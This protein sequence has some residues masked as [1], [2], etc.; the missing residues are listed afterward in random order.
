MIKKI[1]SFRHAFHSKRLI[2][3]TIWYLIRNFYKDPNK[4]EKAKQR[5]VFNYRCTPSSPRSFNEYNLWIKYN[6]LNDFWKR[7]ADKIECKKALTELGFGNHCSKTLTVF[8]DSSEINL[9]SLPVKFVLKTNHDSGSVFVC[10]KN[11]TD[12]ASIFVKLDES[13]KHNYSSLNKEWFYEDIRP[14]I[15]AEEYLEPVGRELVDYKLFVFNGKYKCGYT[16]QNRS[17][18]AR[19]TFFVG[20]YNI[21]PTEYISLKPKKK[22]ILQRPQNF[23][24][25]IALA[26]SIGK[27]FDYV[28]VDLY[29]TTKGIVVGELTFASMSGFGT[30]SKKKYDFE[31]GEFFKD[32]IF[33][34]LAHKDKQ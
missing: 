15:F 10:D 23:D 4:R 17:K 3:N 25:M 29:N 7:C 14:K 1:S 16:A 6:Y 27:H 18:D 20:D 26:E 30:F 19:Y 31:F 34:N 11:K 9:D 21:I 24:E 5:L 22:D 13:L 8:N 32:T 2:G 33:Y 28:R 12:F